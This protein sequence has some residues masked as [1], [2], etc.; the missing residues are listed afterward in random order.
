MFLPCFLHH[1]I[2]YRGVL[3]R[4]FGIL[5]RVLDRVLRGVLDRVLDRVLDELVHRL[6]CVLKG[7]QK[8][9]RAWFKFSELP[10]IDV[11]GRV[12]LQNLSAPFLSKDKLAKVSKTVSASERNGSFFD[13]SFFHLGLL[14]MRNGHTAS[15]KAR[16]RIPTYSFPFAS[17]WVHSFA[18]VPFT[19]KKQNKKN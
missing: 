9:F 7:R 2:L 1:R 10:K 6:L 3:N 19:N 5:D 15:V 13:H 18:N 17:N 16:S 12:H 8:R 4:V 14:P 11:L